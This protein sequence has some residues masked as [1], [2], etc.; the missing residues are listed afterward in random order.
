MIV[1]D[2]MLPD[3]DGF[4]VARQLKAHADTRHI[5]IVMLTALD[6]EECRQRGFAAGAVGYLTKPFD[7]EQLLA[8][9]RT[10]AVNGSRG[11]N[12]RH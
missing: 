11:S 2:V 8:A 4:E 6:R 3:L 7:P 9:I 12:G 10:N 5:P 1:L